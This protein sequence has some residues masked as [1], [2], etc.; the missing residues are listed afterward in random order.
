MIIIIIIIS[1]HNYFDSK[2]RAMTAAVSGA[3]ALVPV[4]EVVQ[5]F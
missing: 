5:W 4:N 1:T 2:T 3:E